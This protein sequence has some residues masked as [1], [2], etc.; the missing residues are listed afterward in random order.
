MFLLLHFNIPS[1]IL[2]MPSHAQSGAHTVEIPDGKRIANLCN[3]VKYLV[4]IPPHEIKVELYLLHGKSIY[5]NN[6]IF[7]S[8]P[9]PWYCVC[10]AVHRN[11]AEIN[12]FI[13]GGRCVLLKFSEPAASGVHAAS[14]AF[15]MAAQR[16]R[17]PSRYWRKK[18]HAT[19]SA[20]ALLPANRKGRRYR[21]AKA[22]TL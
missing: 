3:K 21:P 4:L 8:S 12:A 2:C 5:Y 15:T 13:P 10:V 22:S 20:A 7:A 18:P 9:V 14:C 11:S 16:R 17:A 1:I 19:Y 6:I